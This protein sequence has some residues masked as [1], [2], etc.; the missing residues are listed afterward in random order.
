[1]CAIKRMEKE[2][3]LESNAHLYSHLIYNKVLQGGK[4]D[5]KIIGYAIEKKDIYLNPYF[6]VLKIYSRWVIK[7]NMKNR[8]IKLEKG[9]RRIFMT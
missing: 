5:A 7:P 8:T 9:N 4:E 2:Y 6:T 1:M 3:S